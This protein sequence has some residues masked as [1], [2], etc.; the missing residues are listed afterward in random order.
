MHIHISRIWP[1]FQFAWAASWLIVF[2]GGLYVIASID[3]SGHGAGFGGLMT[4]LM[5]AFGTLVRTGI[6]RLRYARIPVLLFSQD[7]LGWRDPDTP[8]IQWISYASIR[9]VLIGKNGG[10]LFTSVLVIDADGAAPLRLSSNFKTGIESLIDHFKTCCVDLQG[11]AGA[12]YLVRPA[13]SPSIR[14]GA[15]SAPATSRH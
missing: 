3:E 5:I 15:P 1:C 14:P 9:S 8:E 6:R 13:D 2:V 4:G 7:E 11:K 10:R 12:R